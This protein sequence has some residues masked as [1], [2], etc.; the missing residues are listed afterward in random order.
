MTESFLD[1][2]VRT[3][4]VGG[5]FDERADIPLSELCKDA[6]ATLVVNVASK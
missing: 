1:I 3:I 4:A 2:R 6:K 5:K